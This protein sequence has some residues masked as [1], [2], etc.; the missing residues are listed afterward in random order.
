MTNSTIKYEMIRFIK[1]EQNIII[2][3]TQSKI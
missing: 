1:K 3:L 2:K